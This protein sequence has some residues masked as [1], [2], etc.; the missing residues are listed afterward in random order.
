VDGKD[1]SFYLCEVK[2]VQPVSGIGKT[3]KWI[4]PEGDDW[5]K[6]PDTV[7]AISVKTLSPYTAE[8]YIFDG[9][10]TYVTNFKQKFGYDGEMEQSIRSKSDDRTKQSFLHWNQRSDKGRRVG[11]GIYIWK[12]L[13]KFEDGHKETRTVKTGVYRKGDKKKSSK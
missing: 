8:V 9:I 11:T 3:A 7:S 2:P 6:L 12:I 13:F 10:A 5:E 1:G 4:P